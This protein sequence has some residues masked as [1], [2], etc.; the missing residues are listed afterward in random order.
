MSLFIV[1]QNTKLLVWPSS[2]IGQEV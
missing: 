1:K 2:A